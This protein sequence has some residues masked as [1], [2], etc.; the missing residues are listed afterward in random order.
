MVS[1]VLLSSYSPTDLYPEP[2]RDFFAAYALRVVP[3]AL[4]WL[5]IIAEMSAYAWR[6][7]IPDGR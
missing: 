7:V 4:V 5:V 2:I 6:P 3:C 1:V